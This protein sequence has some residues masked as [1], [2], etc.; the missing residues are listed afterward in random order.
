MVSTI[1][2]NVDIL[3]KCEISSQMDDVPTL[4]TIVRGRGAEGGALDL[5]GRQSDGGFAFSGDEDMFNDC[6]LDVCE[7][8]S[9]FSM[10]RT[11]PL[12]ACSK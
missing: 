8:G 5:M 9:L 7:N 2:L 3:G 1:L 6:G 12:F 10:S 4:R 11:S